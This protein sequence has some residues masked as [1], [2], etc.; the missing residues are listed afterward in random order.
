MG[1]IS[2]HYW[3]MPEEDGQRLVPE[4]HVFTS[5]SDDFKT[6]LNFHTD[7]RF[8]DMFRIMRHMDVRLLAIG[9]TPPVT[10]HP[11]SATT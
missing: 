1:A 6:G 11:S 4:V 8:K 2:S 3:T 9:H 10:S 5:W 7:Q